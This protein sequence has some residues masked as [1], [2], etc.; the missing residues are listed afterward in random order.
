MAWTLLTFP[1]YAATIRGIIGDRIGLLLA[2]AFPGILANAMVGQN[3]FVTAALLGGALIF[4]ERRPLLAGGLIGLL[5]FKPH[6][7]ILIPVALV[8]GGHWRVIA[9][10][11]VTVA[12]LF[13]ASTRAGLRHRRLGG[14]PAGVAGRIAGVADGRTRQLGQAAERVR[15]RSNDR[16]QRGL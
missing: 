16:R 2:C 8:A 10:A 5:S 1:L 15:G 7:G 11:A 14:V 13:V 9:A 4:M 3:G 12:L 6:L